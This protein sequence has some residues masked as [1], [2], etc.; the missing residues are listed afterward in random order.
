MFYVGSQKVSPGFFGNNGDGNIINIENTL[1]KTLN[2]NDKVWISVSNNNYSLINFS[3]E[4]FIITGNPT[5]NVNSGVVSNFSTS[6]YL[7]IPYPF[8]PTNNNWEIVF[9]ITTGS[10]V[11]GGAIFGNFGGYHQNSPQVGLNNGKF[12]I[13]MPGSSTSSQQ[14]GVAG[15]YNVQPNTTYWVKLYFTGYYYYL[16]YSLNGINYT[17]DITRSGSNI[18]SPSNGFNIGYNYFSSDSGDVWKGSIHLKDCYIKINNNISWTGFVS[19]IN[20]NCLSGKVLQGGNQGEM[21][22]VMTIL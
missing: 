11:S 8:A 13:Y 21:I 18:Y 1:S 17:N 15:T 6:D 19:N 22:K 10:D 2:T 16:D 14:F 5:I 7:Q 3:S 9:K 12:M 20:E 4:N